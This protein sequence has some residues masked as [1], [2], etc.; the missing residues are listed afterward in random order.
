MKAGK[1]LVSLTLALILCL[2]CWSGA[3][4]SSRSPETG[5]TRNS[6]GADEP[7]LVILQ[8]EG[9]PTAACAETR[10]LAETRLTGQHT[11]LRQSLKASGLRWEEVYEYK[12]LLNG[13]ALTVSGKDL[14]KLAALSGVK[15][16]HVANSYAEPADNLT[17]SSNEMTGA[18][19]MHEGDYLGSGTVIA[20]LDSGFTPEHEAFGVYDG[21]LEQAKLSR[22]EV[23][24]WI[25]AKGYG[26]YISVKIPFACNYDVFHYDDTEDYSGH[27]THTAAVAAGYAQGEDGTVRFC[28]TAPD[29][30]LLI[31]K[32]YSSEEPGLANS[33]VCFKALED[34]YELGAD[35]INLNLGSMVTSWEE[36]P[37]YLLYEEFDEACQLLRENGVAVTVGAGDKGSMA[38]GSSNRAGSGRV[39]ADYADYGQ[40][41]SFAAFDST[42]TVA[43]VENAACPVHVLRAGDRNIRYYDEDDQFFDKMYQSGEPAMEYTVVPGYGAFEDYA[44]LTIKGRI[45]LVARGGIS[46]EDKVFAA[47]LAGASAVL[48]YND[49]PGPFRLNA[50]LYPIPAAGLSR[51]DGE[52]LISLAELTAPSGDPFE[53]V[54]SGED[55]GPVYY[56]LTD[57]AKLVNAKGYLIV[58]ETAGRAL[59]VEPYA[60]MAPDA[61]YPYYNAMPVT[62][63][64]G[65]IP[66]NYDLEQ[67][68]LELEYNSLGCGKGYLSCSGTKDEL[69]FTDSP[70]DLSFEIRE[71]G[72]AEIECLGCSLRYDSVWKVFCFCLPDSGLIDDPNAKVSIYRRGKA[73][74]QVPTQIGS[75]YIPAEM[76]CMENPQGWQPSAF[77]SMG[78]SS[79][80]TFKPALTGVGGSVFSA[81]YGTEDGY[82]VRSGSS[83]AAAN[84]SGALACMLQ[85]LREKRPELSPSARMELA[86][87]LLMS[88]ARVLTDDEGRI[89]TP[90][91]Q[92][93]G[94]IDLKAAAEARAVITEPV[95]SLGEDDTGTFTLRFEV[96]S[97]CDQTLTY[98]LDLTALC[99]LCEGVDLDSDGETDGLYNALRSRNVSSRMVL[100]G[101]QTLIVPPGETV[102]AELMITPKDELLEELREDY[103]NGAW[104]DGF[105]SLSEPEPP[106]EGGNSCPG[107]PF[108]DMPKPTNW[109]HP[110][111]DFVL[112]HNLFSGTS[113]TTFSPGVT[114]SRGMMVTVLYALAGKPE[115]EGENLFTDVKPGKYYEKPVTWASENGIVSG[116]GEGL[117]NPNGDITREQMALIMY[118]FAEYAG[119]D[120]D[121][122]ADIDGYPDVDRVHSYALTAMRWAVGVGILSG[123]KVDEEILLDPRGNATRAQVARM[124][125]SFVMKCLEPPVQ[126]A[127]LHLSFIGF[128]GDW[129]AAPI[130]EQHDWREIV[131][132]EN[133]L[134]PASNYAA[135]LDYVEFDVN[136]DV[137]KAFAMSWSAL[138]DDGGTTVYLGENPV[139]KTE[140]KEAHAA[141]SPDGL[142]NAVVIRPMPLRESRHLIMTATDAETGE[143]YTAAD[144]R[145]MPK[146]Y[147]SAKYRHWSARPEF[148]FYGKDLNGLALPGGTR[149]E[150]R[151]YADLP[152]GE[153]ELGAI[154]FEDLAEQGSD[155]LEWSFSVTMDDSAPTMEDLRWEPGN[156][157]L[158]F[159]LSDDRYLAYGALTPLPEISEDEEVYY[160]P[161]WTQTFSDDEAGE[162]HAVTVGNVGFDEYELSLWDY[163]GNETRIRLS[164]GQSANLKQVRFVC[165]EGCSPEGADH[166]FA[167][168]QAFLTVPELKGTP[169]EGS[170]IAWISEPLDGVWTWEELEEAA[171]DEEILSPGQTVQVWGETWY[172]ALLAVP[173][174]YTTVEP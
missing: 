36:K 15:S 113:Q 110:G 44:G 67:N 24:S 123:T 4:S 40:I 10:G 170:F 129:D 140:Y 68:D 73:L 171:L 162:I 22:S 89:V 90:R 167:S 35:V 146:A 119:L 109:A 66:R 8:M 94:L 30:Q 133:G 108:E 147:W 122:S 59:T 12:T 153:D 158:S 148:C 159:K 46:D 174:G 48:V 64:N 43:S 77:S 87:A 137:N 57:E 166:C 142:V 103:L 112:T 28:G 157:S 150:I 151:I 63:T 102:S 149:V 130:L 173:G 58:S 165:P 100:L 18:A 116:V 5:E 82:A 52:Y 99:D 19:W 51:E 134:G 118:R 34:A 29:A 92:G 41:S 78:T 11:A 61:P 55:L 49:E 121:F 138:H 111:I 14:D 50:E 31:L 9:E 7:V 85:Y 47:R 74:D 93:A 131:D 88:T 143:L 84:V 13:F 156:C 17:D 20:M 155:W 79:A 154:D 101:D 21:M 96:R 60:P 124:F 125:M 16:L 136:T 3:A 105:L 65:T 163:A 160:D 53:P 95:L 115:P 106:C 1:R 62:I 25:D 128:V 97:L 145:S 168:Y 152:W 70:E 114:M 37:E 72:T 141:I 71:D 80:L 33:A 86:E 54:D 38:T 169:E 27:G 98:S 117:F 172:Y 91:K 45:A 26:T 39:P 132:I 76:V 83:V 164:L 56:R 69:L 126:T 120:T 161:I 6:A 75:L 42:L 107:A 127:E 23:G 144:L 2:S 135:Y 104:L 139:N 81:S 32:I